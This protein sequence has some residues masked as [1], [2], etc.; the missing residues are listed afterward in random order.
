[1]MGGLAI[2]TIYWYTLLICAGIAIFLVFFGDI[3]DFD[4]P[5]DPMLIV[6]WLTFTSLFGYIGEKV[7]KLDSVFILIIS[8]IIATALVFLLNFYVLIPMK[9]AES[10]L[11]ASEKTLEGQVAIVIT[12]I[13]LQG[14]GEIQLKSV[15][16]SIMRPACF[17]APQSTPAKRGEQVLIIEVKK[18]VCYVTPYKGMLKI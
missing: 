11:S 9:N 13:P 4:G 16:G 12:P 10:T 3:F 18:R 15:T 6:P 5:I 1:M 14:M 17:Y 2:E 7:T 8:G